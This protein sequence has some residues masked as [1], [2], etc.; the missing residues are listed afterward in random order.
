MSRF[1]EWRLRLGP[2]GFGVGFRSVELSDALPESRPPALP[3][4]DP[5]AVGGIRIL[6][7]EPPG[8]RSPDLTP[9][10]PPPSARGEGDGP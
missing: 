10:P 5:L 7:E 6:D 9:L 8:E 2:L 4:A 1:L 3:A